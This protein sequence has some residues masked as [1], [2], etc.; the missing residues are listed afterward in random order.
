MDRITAIRKSLTV[1]VCGL[2]GFLPIIG[3]VPAI[4][5]LVGWA[6][7]AS[8]YGK[9]WNPAASYLSWGARLATLGLLVSALLVTALLFQLAIGAFDR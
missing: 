3:I 4:F 5:A 8:S 9:Q 1:F 2:I 6:R 7:V